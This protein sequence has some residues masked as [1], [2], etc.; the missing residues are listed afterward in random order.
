VYSDEFRY[1]LVAEV[2]PPKSRSVEAVC[3][4]YEISSWTL[5]RR[6]MAVTNGTVGQGGPKPRD[7]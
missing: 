4:K 1:R 2:L 6:K 7:R 5:Y 3:E